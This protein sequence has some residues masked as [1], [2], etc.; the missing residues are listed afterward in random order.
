MSRNLHTFTITDFQH[1]D[2]N[3]RGQGC[4]KPKYNEIISQ[5]SLRACQ[6]LYKQFELLLPGSWNRKRKVQDPATW[7]CVRCR[8]ESIP[9]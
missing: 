5:F 1:V 6:S 2:S 7:P 9:H 8:S 4:E 3:S